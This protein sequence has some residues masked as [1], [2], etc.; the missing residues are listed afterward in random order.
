MLIRHDIYVTP[1]RTPE[2]ERSL[3]LYERLDGCALERGQRNSDLVESDLGCERTNRFTLRFARR[4]LSDQVVV[5]I[6]NFSVICGM[7]KG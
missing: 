6:Q 7:I 4:V 2:T 3:F 1:A 5:S